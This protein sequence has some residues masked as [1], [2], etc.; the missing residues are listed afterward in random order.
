VEP[1]V[2]TF[3]KELLL[4]MKHYFELRRKGTGV[5]ILTRSGRFISNI[6]QVKRSI[7]AHPYQ[8][9]TKGWKLYRHGRL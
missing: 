5:S 9:H 4:S 2:L 8:L 1:V 6:A 3:K 7:K